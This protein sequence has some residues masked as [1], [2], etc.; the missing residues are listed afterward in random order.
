MEIGDVLLRDAQYV[1]R[2]RRALL[3]RDAVVLYVRKD[4]RESFALDGRF[5]CEAVVV[6]SAHLHSVRLQD[7]QTGA[8]FLLDTR[9]RGKKQVWVELFKNVRRL[10]AFRPLTSSASSLST[11]SSASVTLNANKLEAL[12][13]A[14]PFRAAAG[15]L[16]RGADLPALVGDSDAH[17]EW[18][19]EQLIQTG[20]LE[21][22]CCACSQFHGGEFIYRVARDE[23]D[24]LVQATELPHAA[25]HRAPALHRTRACL[26]TPVID[27]VLETVS[28]SSAVSGLAIVQ[29]CVRNGVYNVS[30]AVVIANEMLRRQVL[31][32]AQAS[33]RHMAFSVSK[34]AM[35]VAG[36]PLVVAPDP[37]SS[38]AAPSEDFGRVLTEY[39]QLRARYD[40]LLYVF[41]TCCAL[42]ALDS[43]GTATV[44]GSVKL[45]V[46]AALVA[47][48]TLGDGSASLHINIRKSGARS[49]VTAAFVTTPVDEQ[50]LA[51]STKTP[52]TPPLAHKVL[53]STDASTKSTDERALVRSA[54]APILTTVAPSAEATAR[55]ARVHSFRLAIAQAAAMPLDATL[56]YTDEYLYSVLT[57]KD[58]AFSY[59]VTKIAKCLEWRAQYGVDAITLDD[60]KAQLTSGSMYWYG[61]DFENRPILWVRGRLKDWKHMAQ[62]R[63]AEI[64]AHVFLLEAGSRELMPPGATTY[65]VVTDSAKLGPSHMDLRLMHGLLDTCVAHYPDR[66]GMV[67]A[68]PMTRFLSWVIPMLWPFLPVRLRHKVSFMTDCVKDLSK[69]MKTELIPKHLGGTA[70]HVLRPTPA[71][72]PNDDA[73]DVL[74]MLEQQKR[75]M[76]EIARS[77]AASAGTG[78]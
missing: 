4:A 49:A 34:D 60:V 25:A 21:P 69:F 32:P 12:V 31:A 57:V 37:E 46:V 43:W 55:E 62:R 40:V 27:R 75:R 2:E 52:A 50:A 19:G 63:E 3:E 47:W 72:G 1:W 23:L 9:S 44:P 29:T 33:T 67:H 51:A 64:K 78:E 74:F 70:D 36:Q 14:A 77:A 48:L 16:I 73:M 39:A 54:T 15:K 56:V 35:Y 20:V 68:G 24:E 11:S 18:I 7:I 76:Q 61:Y 38:A 45:A 65:T 71:T 6:S 10:D 17:V 42:V 58:R 66:V 41:C 30:T 28:Q 26:L 22:C 5:T 8:E 13:R 53:Q 59:A